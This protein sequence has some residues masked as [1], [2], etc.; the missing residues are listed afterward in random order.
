MVRLCWDVHC[1]TAGTPATKRV[2]WRVRIPIEHYET[3]TVDCCDDH[4][5]AT[6][7]G[8]TGEIVEVLAVQPLGQES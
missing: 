4:T 5:Q 8:Q 7:F 1:H 3:V 6:T 2:T